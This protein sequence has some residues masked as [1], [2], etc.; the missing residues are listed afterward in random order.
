[1][2]QLVKSCSP[3]TSGNYWPAYVEAG[4][5]LFLRMHAIAMYTRVPQAIYYVQLTRVIRPLRSVVGYWRTTNI[6]SCA[7]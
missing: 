7:T 1:M 6:S 5:S 3:T 2:P 4:T